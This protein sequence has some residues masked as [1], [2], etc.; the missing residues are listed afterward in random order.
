[1]PVSVFTKQKQSM[2]AYKSKAPPA[3]SQ[4]VNESMAKPGVPSKFVR[5]RQLPGTK[6]KSVATANESLPPPALT[7]QDFAT[8]LL[9]EGFVQSYVDFFH[10]TNRPDP[11]VLDQGT[12]APRIQ[13]SLDDMIFIRDNLMQA[14]INRRQGNTSRVY[15]AFNK[16]ADFYEKQE[17]FQTSIFFHKKC[18]DIA[19]MTS[20]MRA[21]MAAD[22]ALGTIYQKI[23][24]FDVAKRYH[25]HHE[26]VAQSVDVFD[27]IVK[28]NTQLY[29]VY[30]VLADQ[31]ESDAEGNHEEALEL[32]NKSLVAAQK[33]M[34]KAAEGE[35]NGK[36]GAL[37]LKLEMVAESVPYLKQQSQIA[38]DNGDPES[39]CRACSSLALAFDKL[40]ESEKAL[41]ELMLVSTISE[42]AGDV[43]LQ[44]SAN[45]ALGTLF[46][47]LGKLE[48]SVDALNKHFSL[49]KAVLAKKDDLEGAEDITLADLDMAR[50]Y[51]GIAKGN[52]MMGSYLVAIQYDFQSVLNWKLNRAAPPAS[53]TMVPK[54]TPA[55]ATGPEA[56]G[57]GAPAA[58]DDAVV[59]GSV[60]PVAA[61]G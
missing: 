33:S 12:N 4:L 5:N 2:P 23:E 47:K 29:E 13:V 43:L 61:S 60:E 14:E 48:E 46:S 56:E 52:L 34:D 40:G 27:D 58:G 31:C 32:Y 28:A 16:L 42:Q 6:A 41:A 21:E 30:K 11:T 22:H 37:L 9:V 50:V 8:Q 15:M 17:D 35:A 19:T 10:L 54:P 36:I 44:T 3:S 7:D 38:S 26:E 39:R 49:L 55:L 51:V 24:K 59:T 1:M 20:D 25:E 45:R 57:E 53:Q 18:L